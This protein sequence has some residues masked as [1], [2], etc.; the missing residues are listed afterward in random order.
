[1]ENNLKTAYIAGIIDGEG[2]ITIRKWKSQG[3]I[4]HK[5]VIE[6]GMCCRDVVAF[7]ADYFGKNSLWFDVYR[8]NIK[9]K[10]IHKWRVTG[11]FVIPI[12]EQILPF[13]IEKRE[14]AEIVLKLA[15]T[16]K[17]RIGKRGPNLTDDDI[18]ERELLYQK[19]QL[20]R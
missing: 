2:C 18:K 20:F 8:K 1:M 16:M 6:L 5:P 10:P 9:W 19:I 11:T 15:R 17:K 4:Y 12:L 7:V 13:L 14:Q 3:K